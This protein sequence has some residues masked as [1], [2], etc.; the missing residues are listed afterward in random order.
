MSRRERPFFMLDSEFQE[1]LEE[2]DRKGRGWRLDSALELRLADKNPHLIGH[3]AVFNQQSEEIFGFYEVLAPGAFPKALEKS[4]VRVLINH[5]GLP[6]ARSTEWNSYIYRKIAKDWH[7]TQI[8]T[9]KMQMC[10]DYC[11]KFNVAISIKCLLAF[12]S[13]R[14]ANLVE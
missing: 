5:E 7:L 11:R 14:W 8:W 2:I 4:D 3:A 12:C 13:S 9:R 6:L 10:R 1:F